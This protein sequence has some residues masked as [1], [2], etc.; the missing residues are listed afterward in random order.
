VH[1][2]AQAVLGGTSD[3]VV[4]GGLQ[5]MS[6]IPI[7]YAMTA[8]EPLGFADPFSGSEGWRQRYGREEVSQFR[9]ADMI[10]EKR[11]LSRADMEQFAVT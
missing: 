11:N 4:A 7:S 8:A 5:N 10:A 1:F 2:A 9:S 6:V 3:V